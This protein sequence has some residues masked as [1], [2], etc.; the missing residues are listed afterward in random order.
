MKILCTLRMNIF[1]MSTLSDLQEMVQCCVLDI[2]YN[3]PTNG[4]LFLTTQSYKFNAIKKLT[5]S[6]SAALNFWAYRTLS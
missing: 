6:S 1:S 4:M 5:Y 3:M 2:L